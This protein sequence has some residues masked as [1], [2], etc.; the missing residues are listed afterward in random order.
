MMGVLQQ[1]DLVSAD[2][3]VAFVRDQALL[4]LQ[5]E[6]RRA[7]LIAYDGYLEKKSPAHN[8]WQRRFFKFSTKEIAV[9]SSSEVTGNG[10]SIARYEYQYSLMW[11]KK[12][13]GSVI[14]AVDVTKFARIAM[15]QSPRALSFLSDRRQVYLSPDAITLLEGLSKHDAPDLSTRS[16]SPRADITGT[17]GIHNSLIHAVDIVEI[18]EDG[19]TNKGILQEFYTFL[20]VQTDGKEHVLRGAKVDRVLKWVNIIAAVSMYHF[21]IVSCSLLYRC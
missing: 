6:Q 17:L 10:V 8:L 20:I 4:E 14:K 13:G 11:F 3:D 1:Q 9:D 5:S 19:V 15:I 2:A 16:D 18:K 7:G 12:E 21:I